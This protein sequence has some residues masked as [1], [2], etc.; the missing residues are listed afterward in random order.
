MTGSSRGIGRGC[1]LALAAAGADVVVTYHSHPE[2][3]QETARQ[4]EAYGRRA[5]V[6]G[7]NVADR[8]VVAAMVETA[9][10]T[11]GHLDVA[12][13]N[14]Y[15]SI[16]KPF[17]ELL[18]EDFEATMA[19]SLFG[20][21]HTCQLAAQRMVRQ[22]SGGKIIIVS[23]VLAE[24]ALS[25]SAPYNAA[26]AGINQMARTMANE[27]ARH[28]TNVNVI[29]PGWIDTPGERL[30]ATEEEIVEGGRQL[31]WGRLGTIQ[32]MGAVA[33]FLASEA[34]S[35]VSGSIIRADGAYMAALGEF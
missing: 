30:Y 7:G 27:L 2:D 34:A 20:T 23:S 19:V 24:R 3:A 4:V 17:L 25:T 28:R 35:Y 18:P 6:A 5:V 16:R 9:V 11:F 14:A 22:G 29:E 31:P 32:E 1:A 21:F 33:A 26:K 10:H 13:A 12:V 8:R 15:R